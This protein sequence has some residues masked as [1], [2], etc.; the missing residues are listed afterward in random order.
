MATET[1]ALLRMLFKRGRARRQ[2]SGWF[3]GSKR[4]SKRLSRL[5]TIFSSFSF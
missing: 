5:S 1:F 4:S 2:T 3:A